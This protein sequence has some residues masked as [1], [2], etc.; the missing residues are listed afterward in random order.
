MIDARLS[1]YG[2]DFVEV[3]WSSVLYMPERYQVTFSCRLESNNSHYVSAKIANISPENCLLRVSKLFPGT[4]CVINL[5]AVYNPA[6]IDEGITL[7]CN[8]SP[9]PAESQPIRKTH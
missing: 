7:I 1:A 3:R 8:T 5:I 6:S 2:S 4:V 9:V